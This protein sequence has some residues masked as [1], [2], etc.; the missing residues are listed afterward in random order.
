VPYTVGEQLHAELP[1]SAFVG[2]VGGSHMLPVTHAKLLAA[3]I[4]ELAG[5]E[6]SAGRLPTDPS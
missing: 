1:Q 3:K 5:T 4:H 2:I 6:Y